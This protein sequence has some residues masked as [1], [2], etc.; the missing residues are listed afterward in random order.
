M[1]LNTNYIYLVKAKHG[2]LNFTSNLF[3]PLPIIQSLIC[4]TEDQSIS[5]ME[6]PITLLCIPPIPHLL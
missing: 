5:K 3:F 4:C 6:K 2:D 1:L